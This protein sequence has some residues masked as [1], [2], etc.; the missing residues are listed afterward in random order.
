MND[1]ILQAYWNFRKLTVFDHDLS[2]TVLKD[3]YTLLSNCETQ[4]LLDSNE[5]F[6]TKYSIEVYKQRYIVPYT[7]TIKV[8]GS[9]DFKNKYNT[10]NIKNFL[11]WYSENVPNLELIQNKCKRLGIS[12]PTSLD[13]L[14]SDGWATYENSIKELGGMRI[15]LM[16]LSM[17]RRIE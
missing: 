1:I 14:I 3:A 12:P 5:Y 16:D 9:I 15:I 4:L 6:N 8:I 11:W 10:R 13:Y 7:Y 17:K 2:R